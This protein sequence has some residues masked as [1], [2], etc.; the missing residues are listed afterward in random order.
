MTE[1]ISH[2]MTELWPPLRSPF[3]LGASRE[4]SERTLLKAAVLDLR[5]FPV[6]AGDPPDPPGD[7]RLGVCEGVP[8]GVV[9][10]LALDRHRRTRLWSSFGLEGRSYDS[11]NQSF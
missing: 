8:I 11:V 3:G 5:Y 6:E 4:S 2:Q 7:D 1:N 10:S 9:L